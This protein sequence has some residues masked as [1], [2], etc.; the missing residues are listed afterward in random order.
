MLRR[1]CS[2]VMVGEGSTCDASNTFFLWVEK[3][4]ETMVVL[5][6]QCTSNFSMTKEKCLLFTL[7]TLPV[8]SPLADA[9]SV[10]KGLLGRI[11]RIS[12]LYIPHS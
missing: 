1:D 10:H 6:L 5:M 2:F 4:I 3:A 11:F 9:A 8:L 12:F 7:F